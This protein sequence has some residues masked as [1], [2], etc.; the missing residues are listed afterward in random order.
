M[1]RNALS[2]SSVLWFLT[3]LGWNWRKHTHG[4]MRRNVPLIIVTVSHMAIFAIC[5]IFSSRVTSVGNEVLVQSPVCGWVEDLRPLT[6][7]GDSYNQH[8]YDV[9]DALYITTASTVQ[10]GSSYA[11]QCYGQ[12]ANAWGSLCSTYAQP[13][14]DSR[15]DKRA[16]CPFPDGVCNTTDAFSVDS[17]YVDSNDHFGINMPPQDRIKYR[18]VTSCAP[19]DADNRYSTWTTDGWTTVALDN[20]FD[21]VDGNTF[22]YYDMGSNSMWN[23]TFTFSY[24]NFSYFTATEP[25]TLRF[26]HIWLN[27]N[28]AARLTRT[29][30]ATPR[31]VETT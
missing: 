21:H 12:S 1:L 24:S 6:T 20:V 15:I 14:V 2:D 26:V 27:H 13:R 31:S 30:E 10:K 9:A 8:D 4:A 17:G 3:K 18:K 7:P 25:Y 5:G 11:R 28:N 22:V 23:T 29:T 16:K 19:V